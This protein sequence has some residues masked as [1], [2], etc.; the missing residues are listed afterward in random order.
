[1]FKNDFPYFQNSKTTY[2]DNG[3]T[4]Q[5]PKSVI[6]SQVEYYEHYCSNTHRS[7]F[8]DAN[9]ATL[10]FE[11]TRKILKEFINASKKEEIIFTKGVTESLN[12]IATSF[13]L[14]FKTV[15]ISSLEHHSNIVPW[16]MQGRTLGL[17]L[18]VVNCDD[19]LNFDM[20]H[21]EKLLKA[22]PNA[23][24]SITHI[25]NAF[26][27]IHDIET[28]TK[29]AHSYGAIVM[30]DGAQSLAHTSI[31]VQALDVDFFAISGHKTFA[32]TGV[33][34]IYIKEKYLKDVKPYQTGGATIHEVDFSG[35][36]LLDSPYKF[37]AGTQNIAGVIGFGKALEYL[38]Y[39][40][41]ENIQSIE[42]N[43]FKYLDE[44]LAKLPDIVFYNDLEN[45]VG[46]RSF[47][48]KGIV[49]DDIGI[50]LDKMKVAVRVG[51]HCA[52]P[53]MKKLGIKGT[54][55]VSISFYND[56]VDVDNLITALKKA[57][58]MLRD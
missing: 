27:K 55:R 12:F 51:H 14:S 17:G 30:I 39:V 56:Y 7:N 50:L 13:A 32:P 3:A 15:I 18:E 9:K 10:E 1:M 6:D 42:H 38:N 46:S 44:E 25:S 57:L 5:K 40:K 22:N 8:G 43:V 11:K 47:N 24:V 53:I 34:A 16:H 2:L 41:Y 28:I 45:C 20:N 49:H 35:S 29:L 19:N 52:Q 54:I 37:E 4:T 48:F 23:F 58:N 21:F 33:G 31:D 26:G 36:T